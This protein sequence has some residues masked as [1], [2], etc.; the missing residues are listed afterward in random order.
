M[1]QRYVD[2]NFKWDPT[3]YSQRSFNQRKRK[4][5]P[6]REEHFDILNAMDMKSW[7]MKWGR[8]KNAWANQRLQLRNKGYTIVGK[9]PSSKKTL[10]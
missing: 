5:Q 7:T 1:N 4:P 6:L 8:T 2:P 10:S 3:E 9:R